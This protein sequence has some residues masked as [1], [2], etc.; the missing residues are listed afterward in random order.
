MHGA[1]SEAVQK[2]QRQECRTDIGTR[3]VGAKPVHILDLQKVDPDKAF[4]EW[5]EIL[6]TRRDGKPA[7]CEA[8]DTARCSLRRA[9]LETEEDRRHTKPRNAVKQLLSQHAGLGG[10]LPNGETGRE[11]ISASHTAPSG[12]IRRYKGG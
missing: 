6:R 10:A 4:D 5:Q 8:H 9:T 12:I 11:G 7:R 1:G 2:C 3:A